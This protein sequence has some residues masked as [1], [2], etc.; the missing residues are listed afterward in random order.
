M[1]YNNTFSRKNRRVSQ[2]RRPARGA[3]MGVHPPDLPSLSRR[4][5]CRDCCPSVPPSC[6]RFRSQFT[7]SGTWQSKG[8]C[9]SSP[10][11][12]PVGVART[13]TSSRRRRLHWVAMSRLR[14]SGERSPAVVVHAFS[15]TVDDDGH[16]LGRAARCFGRG[17]G[18]RRD[19]SATDTGPDRRL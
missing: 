2:V 12:W 18:R 3:G 17:G 8:V 7:P 10:V 14:P 11:S 16:H 1:N 9:P 4:S 15:L 5:S 19:D 13:R 6:P